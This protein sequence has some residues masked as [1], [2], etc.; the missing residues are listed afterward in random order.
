M[1]DE[2]RSELSRQMILSHHN[3]GLLRWNNITA[4]NPDL[5]RILGGFAFDDYYHLAPEIVI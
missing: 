4:R 5:P 2:A 1:S 3:G